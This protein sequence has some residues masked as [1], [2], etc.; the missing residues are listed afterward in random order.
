MRRRLTISLMAVALCA[1]IPVRAAESLNPLVAAHYPAKLAEEAATHH[2][3]DQR[4]QAYVAIKVDGAD[5]VVAAY[6]NGH[7]GA[8]ALIDASV[9]P[10]VTLQIIRDHQTGEHP[11]VT[12]ADL[13]ADGRPEVVVGFAL[14]PRGG[15]ATWIYR[16]RQRRLLSIGPVGDDGGTLLGDPSILD[17]QGDGVMDLIDAV[18][19]GDSRLDP[20]IVHEHYALRNGVYVA[21][22]RADYYEVFWGGEGPPKN[23]TRTFSV[24]AASR[25]KPARLVVV[26]GD[27][28]G[29]PYRVSSGKV[30]L[31]GTTVSVQPGTRISPVKL[32]RENFLTVLLRGGKHG[33]RVG[34]VVLHH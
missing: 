23:V 13:D 4:E 5:L 17:L 9:E 31:N 27:E 8:V 20:V 22:E 7:I 30:T 33:S 1:A 16:L 19:V 15:S 28:L 12:A 6:S 21:L 2:Y 14:G 29:A 18:N 26:N 25:R 24:P 34:V 11:A 10:P 32:K 3:A